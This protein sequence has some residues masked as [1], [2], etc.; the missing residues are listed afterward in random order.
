[1]QAN[2]FPELDRLAHQMHTPLGCLRLPCVGPDSQNLRS[3]KRSGLVLFVGRQLPETKERR[4]GRSSPFAHFSFR[5]SALNLSL[6]RRRSE[7]GR[8]DR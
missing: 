5:P 4:M 7:W 8:G 2:G 1:M 3:E 6:L